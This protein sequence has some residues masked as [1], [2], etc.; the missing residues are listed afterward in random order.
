MAEKDRPL[1][2]ENMTVEDMRRALAATRTV[3]VP[4]GVTE[5]HGYHLPLSEEEG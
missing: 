1:L 3:L 5:Q 4:L 2:M